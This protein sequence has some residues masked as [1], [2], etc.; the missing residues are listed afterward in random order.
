MA[1][2][3]KF[4]Q[5][6]VDQSGCAMK[7]NTDG[8]LLGAFAEADSPE[9]ILDIGTGT[10]VIALMLAQKF[11]GAHIDAV[12]VDS[13]AAQTAALNFQQSPFAERLNLMPGSFQ[14]YFRQYPERKYD[15]IIANP[16]FYLHSLEAPDAQRNLARHTDELF[17]EELVSGASAQ[18]K[19]EGNCWLI[20][21]VKTAGLVKT[22][23]PQCG[24][25]L[26]KIISIRSFS[27]S[28]A[29]REI[30]VFSKLNTTPIHADFIIYDEPKMYTTGY[31]NMLKDFFTIF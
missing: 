8:V 26:N 16:P 21:P 12:E 10:G 27:D 13:A 24:L 29:H 9:H 7:I 25:Y 14:E 31:K 20:L 15:L 11:T 28:A 4:K 18:L 19:D 6:S 3:F 5:F 1:G 17:F 30:I 2:I 22:L 23:L